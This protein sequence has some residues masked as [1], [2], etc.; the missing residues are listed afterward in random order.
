MCRFR[1]LALVV[2]ATFA[3]AAP[4]DRAG[5]MTP[6]TP[7]QLGFARVA[8]EPA[9]WGCGWH[10]CVPGWHHYYRSYPLPY[11]YSYPIPYAY[12]A[13][14]FVVPPPPVWVGPGYP[15]WRRW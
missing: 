6:A 14:Y 15:H 3:L 8:A 13:P 11:R 5:A 10:G 2:A 4:I 7:A 9:A 1:F 12:P